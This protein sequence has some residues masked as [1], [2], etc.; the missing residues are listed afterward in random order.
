MVEG[1]ED[2]LIEEKKKQLLALDKVTDN[3]VF[4][5]IMD[6]RLRVEKIAVKDVKMR[7]FITEDTS[8]NDMVEHVY[9]VTYGVVRQRP[10]WDLR[11]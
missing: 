5:R 3:E 9:D 10:C 2:F 11:R 7:T 6:R 4:Q 8:R 1:L